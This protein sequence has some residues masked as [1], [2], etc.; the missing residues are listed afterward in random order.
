MLQW[1]DL[2]YDDAQYAAFDEAG[3]L[4]QIRSRRLELELDE[5]QAALLGES[6][7]AV[8]SGPVPLTSI[9][10]PSPLRVSR[11]RGP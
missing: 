7:T 8:R 1:E 3:E 11:D 2:I 10:I 9:R 6:R 5:P 4:L